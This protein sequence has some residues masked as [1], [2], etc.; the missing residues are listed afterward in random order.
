MLDAADVFRGRHAHHL[1]EHRR[2]IRAR[3]VAQLRGDG[4][5][6]DA[7]VLGGGQATAGLLDAV[8]VEQPLEVGVVFVADG[9]R[10]VV[11]VEARELAERRH[12]EG[13]AADDLRLAITRSMASTM[14]AGSSTGFCL[15]GSSGSGWSTATSSWLLAKSCWLRR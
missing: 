8:A 2:E 10:N 5:D 11:A 7:V 4:F 14:P 15:D 3:G 9:L 13:V 6:G 1:L 12:G